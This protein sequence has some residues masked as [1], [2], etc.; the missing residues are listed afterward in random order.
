[1]AIRG[2]RGATTVSKNNSEEIIRATKK[3]L[4]KIVKANNL[5]VE[6]IASVIFST[7][8]DLNAQFPALAARQ[9][10][11]LYTPLICTHEMKV[12]GGLK[13]CLRILLL[14]NTD[15]EQKEMKNIY[16]GKAKELRPDLTTPEQDLYYHS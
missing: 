4:E 10:G 16:L 8:F 15:K 13:K 12:K 7:T 6:D 9:I 14:V 11:W 3:L 5:K 1:M 2:I